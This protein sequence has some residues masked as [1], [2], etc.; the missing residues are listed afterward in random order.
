MTCGD[1]YESRQQT[2]SN[3]PIP[4]TLLHPRPRPQEREP[5][6]PT[7]TAPSPERLVSELSPALA[8]GQ[9]QDPHPPGRRIFGRVGGACSPFGSVNLK[10]G[11]METLGLGPPSPLE[12]EEELPTS[13]HPSNPVSISRAEQGKGLESVAQLSPWAQVKASLCSWVSI[14]PLCGCLNVSV[15]LRG[16]VK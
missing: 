12:G 8:P 5:G 2:P 15:C 9:G 16:V 14:L 11:S 3:K 1:R 13:S 4:L 7:P 6:L 10:L